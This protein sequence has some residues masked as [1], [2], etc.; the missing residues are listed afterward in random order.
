MISFVLGGL[1]ELISSLGPVVARFAS[2]LITK[3]SQI[4][5]VALNVSKAIS[6]VVQLVAENRGLSPQGED[7]EELGYK[8]MQRE[9]RLKMED[10][11]MEDYLNYLRNEVSIDKEKLKVLSDEEKLK[12]NV[13]GTSMLSQCISEKTGIEISEDF[14]LDMHKMKMNGELLSKY[15]D[16]FSE[17]GIE[18]LDE[19]TQYLRGELSDK[20]SDKIETIIKSVEKTSDPTLSDGDVLLKVDDMKRDIEE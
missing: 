13:M 12:C 6:V 16:A 17:M 15:I 7:V 20:E 19:L 8:A 18:T 2:A 10:E 3:L 11:S 1:G 14:L 9:A 5:D 4:V